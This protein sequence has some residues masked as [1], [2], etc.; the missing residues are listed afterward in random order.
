[1]LSRFKKPDLI[2][3]LQEQGGEVVADARSAATE[4]VRHAED[5]L[6]L[7]RMELREYGQRQARRMVA[8]LAGGVLLLVSYLLLCAALC[9]LLGRWLD[10]PLAVGSVFLVNFVLG[11]VLLICGVKM[12]PGPVAPATQQE[13]KN[14]LQCLKLAIEQKRKSW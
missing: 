10:W 8:I 14:D 9:V 7:F 1:M 6:E 3:T 2:A 5:L 12:K 13:L 4:A 11:L